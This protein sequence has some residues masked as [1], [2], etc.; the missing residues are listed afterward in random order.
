[1]LELCG[2]QEEVEEEPPF[3]RVEVVK[4]RNELGVIEA[5]VTRHWRTW[6]QFFC[7]TCALSSFL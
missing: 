1:V 2:R 6:V 4:E 3:A 5:L 7:S